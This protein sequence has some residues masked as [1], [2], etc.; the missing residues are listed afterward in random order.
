MRQ[1]DEIGGMR[2][3]DHPI[4]GSNIHQFLL[5]R[6]VCGQLRCR[7]WITPHAHHVLSAPHNIE[8]P[9]AALKLGLHFAGPPTGRGH[10]HVAAA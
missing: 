9:Y 3:Q 10:E 8:Q 6:D 4:I 5:D 7:S 1:R 2:M